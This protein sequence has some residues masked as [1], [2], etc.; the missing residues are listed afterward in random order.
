MVIA[1]NSRGEKSN[2]MNDIEDNQINFMNKSQNPLVKDIFCSLGVDLVGKK[3]VI[4][5]TGSVAAY[6]AID[7]TRLLIRHGAEIFPVMS[8]GSNL[9]L[10]SEIMKWASGNNVITKLSANLEHIFLAD[11]NRSDLILV[12]PCTA[13]TIGKMASGIDDTPVTSILSV[14]LGSK[15]PILIAPA[16]HKSMYFNAFV[17]TN[18][19]RLKEQGV[20][21]IDPSISE[22]KA[23]LVEPEEVLRGISYMFRGDRTSLPRLGR[24]I[25][26]EKKDQVVET[27]EGQNES[28]LGRNILI[29]AGSTV[30]FID[31]IRVISNLSSGRMG[32]AIA[33]EAYTKGANVTLVYGHGTYE[34]QEAPRMRIIKVNTSDEMCDSVISELGTKYYDA[35]FMSAA[36]ADFK[37]SRILPKKIETRKRGPF[38]LTLSSTKKIVDEMRTASK[39]AEIFLVAFKADYN[40]SNEEMANHALKKMSEGRCDLVVAIDVGR[41]GSEM[42]SETNEA[43]VVDKEKN[44][45]FLPLQKKKL[46]A[47]KLLEHLTAGLQS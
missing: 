22:N 42:G 32:N 29:T 45:V 10:T 18:I 46:I 30:E 28:L 4:C 39:N 24:E 5:I 13:N 40:K 7:L 11:Y 8:S 21:F 43:I 14:A 27:D 19:Q 23:K 35:A 9:L 33:Q 38:V 15:I 1:K 37:P 41:K 47:R 20:H 3:I 12:Y 36:V 26:H 2:D 31:P 44:I 6:K 16:M 25:T 17:T 34:L